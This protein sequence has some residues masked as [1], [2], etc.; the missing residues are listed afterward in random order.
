MLD[1]PQPGLP[2]FMRECHNC[3]SQLEEV[4][5]YE[6]QHGGADEYSVY[7]GNLTA[8]AEGTF[9]KRLNLIRVATLEDSLDHVRESGCLSNWYRREQRVL[10]KVSTQRI[11]PDCSLP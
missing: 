9:D 4:P 11:D 1:W 3:P 10:G 2:K 8:Q 5:A 7:D 6:G